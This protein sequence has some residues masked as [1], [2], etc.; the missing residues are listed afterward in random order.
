[1][2][3]RGEHFEW[4]PL[5][6]EAQWAP[7]LG[8]SVADADGDGADDIFLAQNFFATRK[9]IP[10]LDAGRGL[11]LRNDGKGRFTAMRGSDS[12][13]VVWGE[14]RGCA[15]SDIDGDGKVDL[16][17]TQNGAETKLFRNQNARPGLRVRLRGLAGNPEAIGAVAR[18]KYADGEGPAHEIRGASTVLGL[19]AT[20]VKVAVRWPGGKVSEAAVLAGAKEITI[21]NPK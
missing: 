11:W 7:I 3:N 13:V 1:L 15:T 8:I 18:V 14:G 6:Q 17:V 12:G 21:E 19:R 16:V 2:L 10:R 4:L 9:E 5:P 20:P